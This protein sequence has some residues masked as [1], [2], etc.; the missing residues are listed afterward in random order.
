MNVLG[1]SCEHDSGAVLI[2]NGRILAA[3]NE[4]RLSRK[5]L[6]TGF[7][8]LA[9]GEVLNLSGVAAHEV[10]R[11]AVASFNHID[12]AAWDW[13]RGDPAKDLLQLV[14]AQAWGK[15]DLSTE[16]GL[17]MA[18]AAGRLLYHL[19]FAKEVRER[20]RR[21][22]FRREPEF[23]DH[24]LCHNV[25]A[26]ATSGFDRCLAISL[27]AQGDGHC[28]QAA[29]FDP[30]RGFQTVHKVPFFHSPAHY[31]G[32]VTH[33]LGF[34]QME[35]EGKV[36]GLAA[37]GD[38]ERTAHIFRERIGFDPRRL[39]FVNRGHYIRRE[40][41]HLKARLDGVSREDASAGV[42]K[43][44]EEV[45]LAYVAGLIERYCPPSSKITLAGGVF[46]NVLL[47]QK[48]ARLP[49]VEEV[50]IFP[51]MGDGGL[52]AGAGFAAVLAAG[53]EIVPYRFDDLYLGT[54][55]TDGGV[56]FALKKSGL[57]SLRYED[58]PSLAREVGALLAKNLVVGVAR[59]KMEYGPRALG[60]RSI[61]YQ[62]DDR[63]VN[64]WLNE[65][66][67]RT[68]FMPFA[69][70]VL[71][72][73]ADRYFS[74]TGKEEY[75][76]NFMTITVNVREIGR[77]KTRATTH[78]DGTA[79]P[80]VVYPRH[81]FSHLVLEEYLRLTG[82]PVVINTSFNLHGEPIVATAE[83]A[84][85]SF[86]RSGLDAMVLGDRLVWQSGAERPIP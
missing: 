49:N 12:E 51:H 54:P 47:N 29:L 26:V 8:V 33:I 38:Y 43:V 46:A 64:D 1:I 75:A 85:A 39:R 71:A 76:L 70:M 23:F 21:L 55:I 28:S 5:K 61:L 65:K 16:L 4:E 59:G 69:P 22:G 41:A 25:A 2:Q 74:G 44:L 30:A 78:V 19:P 36:T 86:V 34:K 56:D 37:R 63:S 53:E 62:A 84:A 35:H 73:H 14:L 40:I 20:L 77:R 27:D 79:R 80:Q 3:V 7:P 67:N 48:I 81:R 60:N 66:L 15:R 9:I 57:P 83:D 24:H 31:Y 18:V 58:E 72:S 11:V 45:V 13:S 32:Y 68:E 6:F 17:G 10:D 52:A 42:Q 82:V 50:Y